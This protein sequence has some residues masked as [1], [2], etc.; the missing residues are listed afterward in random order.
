MN[1]GSL[2]R[3]TASTGFIIV[4]IKVTFI[5]TEH[6]PRKID[7]NANYDVT[8]DNDIIFYEVQTSIFLDIIVKQTESGS[9]NIPS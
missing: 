5:V 2:V 9:L 1:L 6:S 8:V 3:A 4:T 7:W